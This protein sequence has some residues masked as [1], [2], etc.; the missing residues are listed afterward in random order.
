MSFPDM[1]KLV[2]GL[3]K[4]V[5]DVNGTNMPF[6]VRGVPLP[7]DKE[8]FVVYNGLA[9]FP[10]VSRPRDIAESVF[11]EVICYSKHAQFRA[12]RDF[13]RPWK[14]SQPYFNL[15][16][17]KRVSV[18]DACIQFTEG[19]IAYLDLRS[20]GDFA[21][22]INQQSPELKLH[23]IVLSFEGLISQGKV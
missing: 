16:S 21:E 12:D 2:A 13:Y 18:E 4:M 22:N 23:C 8:E 3:H 6:Q 17:Q 9:I 7:L 10:R 1:S 11:V 20:L 15:F 19:K 5:Y 14:I